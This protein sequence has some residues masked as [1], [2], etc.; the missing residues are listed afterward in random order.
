V[1]G[2]GADL[3][4]VLTPGVERF[5]YFRQ[6]AR[7][8]HGLEPADGLLPLQDRDDLHFVDAVAWRAQRNSG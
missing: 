3:L 6:L 1:P 4:A 2:T 7:V 5:G 8:Q